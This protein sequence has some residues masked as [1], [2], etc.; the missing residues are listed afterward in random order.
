VLR[1]VLGGSLAARNLY[2]AARPSRSPI[3]GTNAPVQYEE[4]DA[5]SSAV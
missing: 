5:D 3:I 2:P 1:N 4:R